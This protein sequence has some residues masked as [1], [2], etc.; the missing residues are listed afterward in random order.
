[1]LRC[2]A[3]AICEKS[4]QFRIYFKEGKRNNYKFGW[5][6]L[7]PGIH[8]AIEIP[9]FFT[10]WFGGL[11]T[12]AHVPWSDFQRSRSLD[13]LANQGASSILKRKRG[14]LADFYPHR[15]CS[16]LSH[17]PRQRSGPQESTEV[18]K[19]RSFGLGD[20]TQ[21]CCDVSDSMLAQAR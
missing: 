6:Y 12:A 19:A 1:M 14:Y 3:A 10:Q 4:A 17:K 18:C 5:Y 21:S 13:L 2:L 9:L 8:F 20:Q 7:L 11:S 16:S 15:D